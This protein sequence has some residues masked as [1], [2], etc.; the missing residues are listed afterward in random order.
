MSTSALLTY[1]AQSW[2]MTEKQSK[3]FE[4][5]KIKWKEVCL[6]SMR[7]NEKKKQNADVVARLDQETNRQRYLNYWKTK[8]RE[9]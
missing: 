3:R 2:A 9:L 6:G 8:R 4:P 1:G 7:R 5:F